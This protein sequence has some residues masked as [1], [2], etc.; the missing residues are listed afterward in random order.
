MTATSTPHSAEIIA[1]ILMLIDG[2]PDA[3]YAADRAISLS[4]FLRLASRGHSPDCNYEYIEGCVL[5]AS[6]R[7][8]APTK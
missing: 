1:D 6:S 3:I 7:N 4:V 2:A 5:R 8:L